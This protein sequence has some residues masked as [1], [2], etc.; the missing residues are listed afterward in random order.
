MK[1]DLNYQAAEYLRSIEPT[2][3]EQI[4]CRLAVESP[5]AVIIHVRFCHIGVH[6]CGVRYLT[7]RLPTPLLRVKNIS[8][9]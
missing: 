5:D 2:K 9:F 7:I 1:F 4:A 3:R 8:R 6:C